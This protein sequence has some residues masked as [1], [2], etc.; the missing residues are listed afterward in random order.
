MQTANHLADDDDDDDNDDDDDF[1]ADGA[2]GT[3]DNA[4]LCGQF[5]GSKFIRVTSRT[6]VTTKGDDTR[7][8]LKSTANTHY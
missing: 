7:L 8:T 2:A 4:A 1:D 5:T 6:Y 3:A